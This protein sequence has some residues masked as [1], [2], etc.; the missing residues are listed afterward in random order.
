MKILAI[1]SSCD[2]TSVAVIE[3]SSVL[4]NVIASQHFHAEYGGVI[5]EIASRAHL[6]AISG[7]TGAAL[8]QAG[9]SLEQIE[10][11]AVTKEP[12]LA[13]A[14]L[15]GSNF[16]KGLA[17]KLGVPVV[18]VNHI[19]GHI[20]SACIEGAHISFPF[21]SLVVSG[22]HT[23]LFHVE[24]YDKYEMIGSTIDDAAG[25]AFDKI[26][27]MLGLPYPG[28]PVVDRL[29][30]AGDPSRYDF[31]RPLLHSGD[32]NF[33]FSGLKTSVRYF[34][35]KNY[36]SGAEGN[37]LN[38]ICASVQRSITGVLAEKSFRACREYGVKVL[39]TG[40]G[41]SANSELRRR[42]SENKMGLDIHIPAMDYCV[43]NAAMIGFLGEK[44]LLE[45]AGGGY[46]DLTFR[47]SSRAI[48]A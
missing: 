2:E 23:A 32:L 48:R 45:A 36:P 10:G 20:Y 9:L 6:Q 37:D 41:V 24:S 13:G 29:A 34:I 25:E 17:L 26:A 39:V 16:A 12:G 4:S 14:L 46:D 5:P 38:D 30:A 1:E 11:I 42:L 40:G 7:V 44:R 33:S 15:V 28:G 35:R 18:P 8:D 47:V 21:V 43:D 27:K 3:N 22:G 19:E 31:P